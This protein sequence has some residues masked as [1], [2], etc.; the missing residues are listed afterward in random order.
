GEVAVMGLRDHQH[1]HGRLGRD[2]PERQRRVGLLD[3]GGGQL[4]CD[5]LA[6]HAVVH[7][8]IVRDRPARWAGVRPPGAPG[9]PRRAARYR[10][11]RD[12]SGPVSTGTRGARGYQRPRGALS[13]ARAAGRAVEVRSTVDPGR[14]GT[15]PAPSNAA[16]S[17]GVS[18]PS[19]LTT[20]STSPASGSGT[21]ARRDRAAP[22]STNAT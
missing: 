10:G 3:H 4:P 13:T 20:S 7:A 9:A 11:R 21:V 16:S 19:G 15:A 17:A 12:G 1:V 5:D 22:S 8:G 14:T 18:P 2:V 6:E